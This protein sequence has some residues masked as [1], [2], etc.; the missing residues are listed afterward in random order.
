M[1]MDQGMESRY[2]IAVVDDEQSIRTLLCKMLTQAGF[3]VLPYA[4]GEAAY[5]AFEVQKP[6][7]MLLDVFMPGWTG[8]D[9]CAAVRQTLKD[10]ITPIIIM[11]GNDDL[12]SIEAAFHSGATDFF[13]KPLNFPLLIQRLRYALRNT[14]A[15]QMQTAY[16]RS[17]LQSEKMASLGQLAAGIAH[18]INNPIGYV[19]SN[20]QLLAECAPKMNAF[21]QELKTIAQ[22]PAPASDRHATIKRLEVDMALDRF[23][24][25]LPHIMNDIED[26][27]ERISEIVK[28]LKVYAHPEEDKLERTD[29]SELL[30]SVEKLLLGNVK[31]RVSLTVEVPEEPVYVMAVAPKLCQV[32]I[33]LVMNAV[34]SIK[35]DH[36]EVQVKLYPEGTQVHVDVI[37]NGIGME[38]LALTKVFDPFYTTKEIGE[39]TGLGL[40]VSKAIVEKHGGHLSVQSQL[41]EGSLFRVSLPY[42]S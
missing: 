2:T 31:N 40:S 4:S 9:V 1:S 26:G 14:E 27:L 10:D 28:S 33:N 41:G 15:W 17:M 16:Q 36:G 22:S 19:I 11:T 37:D 24:D 42:V 32:F 13:P 5:A 29:F 20:V 3:E 30:V 35:H 21:V 18:E 7:L 8:Y 6:D 38:P 12:Q 39:G 25:D 23:S 34:Q